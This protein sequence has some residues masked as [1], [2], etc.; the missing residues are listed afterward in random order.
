MS[1]MASSP[2]IFWF[3]IRSRTIRRAG[4][5]PAMTKQSRT[6]FLR[7]HQEQFSTHPST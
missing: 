4:S 1:W 6:R 2:T 3:S 5:V 7:E